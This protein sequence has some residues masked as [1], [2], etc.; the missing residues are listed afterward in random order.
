[1][2]HLTLEQLTALHLLVLNQS[3]GSHGIRDKKRLESALAAYR[4]SV[5]GQDQYSTIFDKAAVVCR[6]II[7]DHP[8]VD[9]NKR[10]AMLAS[11]TLLEI[12][13]TSYKFKTGEIENFAVKIAVDHLSVEQIAAWFKSHSK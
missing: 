10:T 9:G 5:F 8:F 4:Q 2:K 7:G 12:N 6:N 3:G 1:M 11:L 13:M